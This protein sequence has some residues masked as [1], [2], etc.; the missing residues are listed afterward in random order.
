MAGPCQVFMRDRQLHHV[1]ILMPS[2]E[3]ARQ[4][5][6]AVGLVEE[7]RGYVPEYQS[8][9]IFAEGNGGSQIELVIPQGGK[10]AEYKDGKPVIHHIAFAVDDIAA[11]AADYAARNMPLLEARAVKGAG[12][13]IVNFLKPRH[14]GGI[15]VEFVQKIS[16]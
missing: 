2:E 5:M 6:Q 13:F 11:V 1:G 8:L 10:L 4:F 14:T 16:S 9:C 3:A 12:D 7:H 15:L